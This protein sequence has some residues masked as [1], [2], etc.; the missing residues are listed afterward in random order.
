[1]SSGL[2]TRR[3]VNPN[4]APNPIQAENAKTG[5]ADWQL[6]NPATS[7]EIEGYASLT[8]VNRGG[9]IS[10]FVSTVDPT[11]TVEIFRLGWYG[12]AGGRRVADAVQH[13]GTKQAIP[14][15]DPDTGL[16]ECQWINPITQPIPFDST[17]PTEWASGFY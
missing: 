16:I 15:P 10:L 6:T 5:T 13:T 4:K 2:R 1:M 3:R 9:S 17:N 12:G 11:Y 14:S 7:N 8:S